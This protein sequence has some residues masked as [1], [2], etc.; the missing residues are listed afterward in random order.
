M[1]DLERFKSKIRWYQCLEHIDLH[2][3]ALD[4]YR[5]YHEVLFV[6]PSVIQPVPREWIQGYEERGI[7]MS[8]V[9]REGLYRWDREVLQYFEKYGTARFKRLALWD[10][11]WN[12]LYRDHHPNEPA[13]TFSDP[14]DRL[15]GLVQRWLK[16]TQ[17]D[18]CLYATRPGLR[19]IVYWLARKVLGRLGW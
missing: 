8:T 9:H 10:V 16:W 17:P 13:K 5:I 7:D 15:T 2:R 12:K 18:F 19:R 6:S 11:D 4:L 3:K 14:R 1:L